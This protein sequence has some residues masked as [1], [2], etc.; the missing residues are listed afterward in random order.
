MRFRKRYL[1]LACA[2]VAAVVGGG[3]ASAHDGN[4]SSLPTWQVVPSALPGAGNGGGGTG[5]LANATLN[6][7]THTNYGHPGVASQSGK[8]VSVVLNFDDDVVVN[9]GTIPNCTPG[10]NGD[11]A[12]SGSTTI[13]TI[14]NGCGPGAADNSYLSPAVGTSGNTGLPAPATS[15][16]SSTAPASNFGGCTLVFKKSQTQLLL[17]A[18]TTTTPNSVANCSSPATNTSGNATIQLTGNLTNPFPAASDFGT[19]LTVPGV[20]ALP[21]P[22]DDFTARVSRGTTF[23]AR[24]MDANNQLNLQGVFDYTA[25]GAHNAAT[26]VVNEPGGSACT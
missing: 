3:V 23:R 19:R 5:A 26:D 20:D 11:P 4:V 25:G 7:Q 13:A 10:A 9:L 14:W 6:V 16:R 24:C 2:S 17:F 15:G 8:V 18:R 12:I 1:I 22:L 21:L